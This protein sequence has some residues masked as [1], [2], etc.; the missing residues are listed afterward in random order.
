M[1]VYIYIYVERETERD[2]YHIVSE[3]GGRDRR[4][5]DFGYGAC[6]CA[7]DRSAQS[8]PEQ[9]RSPQIGPHS[10]QAPIQRQLALLVY[11]YIYIYI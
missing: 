5:I 1:C 2:V 4:E 7:R 11:T 8:D 10:P 6:V 9:P 3:V